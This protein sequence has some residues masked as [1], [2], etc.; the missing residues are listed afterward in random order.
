[1][2]ISCDGRDGRISE[3]WTVSL[4]IKVRWR[5][6]NIVTGLSPNTLDSSTLHH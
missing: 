6:L 2:K 1:M 3:Q 5:I 4:A